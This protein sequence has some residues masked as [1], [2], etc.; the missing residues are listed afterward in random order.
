MAIIYYISLLISPPFL[1]LWLAKREGKNRLSVW[2]ILLAI[3]VAIPLA[4]FLY[5]ATHI[6][7]MHEGYIVLNEL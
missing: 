5:L 4:L 2:R 3:V 7:H 6:P 1:L